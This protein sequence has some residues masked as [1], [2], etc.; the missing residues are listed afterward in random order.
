M[1]ILFCEKMGYRQKY[2]PFY[3]AFLG[4]LLFPRIVK[5]SRR[6]GNVRSHSST[7]QDGDEEP[8]TH[9]ARYD[10]S[11]EADERDIVP[12]GGNPGVNDER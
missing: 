11:G 5:E 1:S 2:G 7:P 6:K 9:E 12:F 10:V 3:N 8:E 4:V